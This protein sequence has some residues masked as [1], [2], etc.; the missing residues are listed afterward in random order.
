MFYLALLLFSPSSAQ[1][2]IKTEKIAII[3]SRKYLNQQNSR[4]VDFHFD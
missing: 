4:T 2:F 1:R 3:I